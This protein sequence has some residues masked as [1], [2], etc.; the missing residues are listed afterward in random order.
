M[1]TST[2]M[3][4]KISQ[5]IQD[6]FF[7]NKEYNEIPEIKEVMFEV[8][9]ERVEDYCMLFLSRI[10]DNPKKRYIDLLENQP[11]II[12]R[13]LQQYIASYIG[14][15]PISLSRIKKKIHFS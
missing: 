15:T 10:K 12:K 3:I 13:I 11:E 14:I 7:N 1:W 4:E 8:L 2:T 5:K 9:L 6:L